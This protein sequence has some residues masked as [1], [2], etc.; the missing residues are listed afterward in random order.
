VGVCSSDTVCCSFARAHA[1]SASTSYAGPRQARPVS[2]PADG[3]PAK[4]ELAAALSGRSRAHSLWHRRRV[5][6]KATTI[7]CSRRSICLMRP[8]ALPLCM[9]IF[10]CVSIQPARTVSC[11]HITKL[12]VL[13]S[14]A[15]IIWL[16]TCLHYDS[17]DSCA[18]PCTL[19]YVSK[20]L[21]TR[22]DEAACCICFLPHAAG[23]DA[24]PWPQAAERGGKASGPAC[25]HGDSVMTAAVLPTYVFDQ[26][27][28]SRQG[29]DIAEIAIWVL[30]SL[31]PSG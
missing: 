15:I 18:S 19:C 5:V 21:Y 12:A 13:W 8:R 28:S 1:H 26:D 24:R 16:H 6:M 23:G 20:A 14:E 25:H 22:V 7:M 3:S 4:V 11:G 9:C 29:L 31:W 10:C 30:T 17:T 2:V 27:S